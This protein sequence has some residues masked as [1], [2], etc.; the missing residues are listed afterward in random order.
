MNTD[1]ITYFITHPESVDK[2]D[3]DSIIELKNKY[4]Y[5]ST[6]HTLYLKTLANSN[7]LIFEEELKK[8]A[9]QVNDRQKL[10]GIIHL[11]QQV[12]IKPEVIDVKPPSIETPVVNTEIEVTEIPLKPVIKEVERFVEVKKEQ[13]T[14][15]QLKKAPKAVEIKKP[16]PTITTKPEKEKP[17][18]AKII[19]EIRLKT[20]AARA[21][22]KLKETELQKS[23]NTVE[24]H[25]TV[26]SNEPK[27][28]EDTTTI[29]V[30]D[31]TPIKIKQIDQ[32]SE[33][34]S[35]VLKVNEP[36]STEEVQISLETEK[37]VIP[38][39]SALEEESIQDKTQ[40]LK[41]DDT[42]EVVPN[43]NTKTKDGVDIDIM[44]QAMEVAFE[45][46]VD[47]IIR[48]V[49]APET[50]EQDLT[51]QQNKE[52]IPTAVSSVQIDQLSFTDWLKVKQGKL[53]LETVS[54]EKIDPS[55]KIKLTKNEVNSL[56]DKFITEEPKMSRPQK[57]FFN[58]VKNAKQ[59][60]DEGEVLVS[61]TLAKIYWI[62]KNYDKAI[63]AYEQ[64][65]LRNPEKSSIFANQIKKIKQ[66]L[67]Q[68]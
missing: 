22:Q 3:L 55:K 23:I 9:I 54:P 38:Q 58:P 8:S 13:L 35:L 49:N 68:K 50:I 19:E 10:H 65:S 5:S 27:K 33:Q 45:L 6:F 44:A 41:N 67:N 42:S 24:D 25:S 1:K 30:E 34:Q 2:T 21:K 16:T 62:Q 31:I 64:L 51:I 48:E 60:L 18:M 39:N 40:D 56:L 29:E 7:S 63:K 15:P 17:D 14:Q 57:N 32:K 61:E 36:K 47:N 12:K 43:I 46:D 52:E 53:K 4:P 59:S 66:E 26:L 11:T 20:E 37:A 28:Q